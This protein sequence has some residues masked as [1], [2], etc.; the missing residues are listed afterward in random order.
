MGSFSIWHWLIVAI[1]LGI[2]V[3]LICWLWKY[4]GFGGWLLLLAIGVW[5]APLR[6]LVNLLNVEEGVDDATISKFSYAFEG[7]KSLYVCLMAMQIALI[8]FMARK[9]QRFVN[10]FIWTGLCTVAITPL[11]LFWGLL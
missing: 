8:I 5:M 11:D 4:R 2:F 9:S 3:G 10:M 7:E 1:A 6:T